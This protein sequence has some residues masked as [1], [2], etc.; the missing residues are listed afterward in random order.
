MRTYTPTP[1]AKPDTRLRWT[2]KGDAIGF[3][4]YANGASNIWLQP[5]DGRPPYAITSFTSGDIYAFDWAKD[6]RMVYSRGLISA[7]VLLIQDRK[8]RQ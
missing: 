1:D 8:A 4:D 2:P 5:I 6:G 3:I 7:D